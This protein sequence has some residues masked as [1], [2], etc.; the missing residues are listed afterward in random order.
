M[1]YGD[2]IVCSSRYTV[3]VNQFKVTRPPIYFSYFHSPPDRHSVDFPAT[4]DI[5]GNNI[6]RGNAAAG[7]TRIAFRYPGEPCLEG[8]TAPT[9]EEVCIIYHVSITII[10]TS[11][12]L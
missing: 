3:V 2:L 6:V 4:F 8:N 9:Y 1:N 5:D 7:S 10:S 11:G 12:R